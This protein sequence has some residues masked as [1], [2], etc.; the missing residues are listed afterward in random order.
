[1]ILCDP[2]I[3]RGEICSFRHFVWAP[4]GH[5]WKETVVARLD[6]DALG[7]AWMVDRWAGSPFP[8]TT[9]LIGKLFIKVEESS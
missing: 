2:Y 9:R 5:T 1:V 3:G 6:L 8:S 4:K 7:G